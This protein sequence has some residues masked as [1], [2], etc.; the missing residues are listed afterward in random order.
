[1]HDPLPEAT[2]SA[3]ICIKFVSPVSG[4]QSS[5]EAQTSGTFPIQ[6]ATLKKYLCRYEYYY[7]YW[8]LNA[9]HSITKKF[10]HNSCFPKA[11]KPAN[12]IPSKQCLYVVANVSHKEVWMIVVWGE[13]LSVNIVTE[14]LCCVNNHKDKCWHCNHLSRTSFCMVFVLQ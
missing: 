9:R 11:G 13:Y 1:M 14:Y 3:I 4:P 5:V 10:G 8:V 12:R 2:Q 6:V 7:I